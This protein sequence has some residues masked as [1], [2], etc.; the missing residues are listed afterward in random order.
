[1]SGTANTTNLV[2]T[3]QATGGVTSPSGPQNYGGLVANG[4][5]VS[6]PFTFTAGTSCGGTL[7]ATFQLQDGA[8]NLGTISFTFTVGTPVF[9]SENFDGVTAPA[10]PA[11]WVA[12]NA[13]GAAPLWVTNITTPDTAPNSAFI[14]DPTT[15]ADKRL[16]TPAFTIVASTAR[17]S[18]RNNFTLE[19]TF[20]GGVLEVSSPNINAGAYTDITNAAVGGSFVS[21]GYTGGIAAA[22]SAINGR[23]AWTGSSGGYIDTVANL[24]P[25]VVG[26]TIKLRFRMASDSSVGAAGWRIDTLKVLTDFSCCGISGTPVVSADGNATVTAEGF[27]PPNSTPD[28]GETVTATFPLKNTGSGPT[29]NL[30]ATLPKFGRNNSGD[31]FSELWCDHQRRSDCVPAVHLYGKWQLR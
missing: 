22:T 21:G 29:T 24:G 28:P 11:G 31:H 26:Q 1:M 7:T 8:A 5:A 9:V 23:Q 19:S 10:L 14:D 18:F 2:A 12:T 6:R 25:N 3:L 15:A 16:E 4:A 30:V 27:T 20:D 17:V 13:T